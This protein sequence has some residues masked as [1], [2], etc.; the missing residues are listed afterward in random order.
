MRHDLEIVLR[1]AKMQFVEL[2]RKLTSRALI[3]VQAEN[4]IQ[5]HEIIMPQRTNFFIRHEI[6]TAIAV[7]VRSGFS[8]RP[9]HDFISFEKKV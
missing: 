5:Q 3:H 4:H 7:L 6:E 9:G 1:I 8:I 2:M